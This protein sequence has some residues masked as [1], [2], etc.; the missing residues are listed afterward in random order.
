M[1]A[2]PL[3]TPVTKPEERSTEA[4]DGSLLVQTPLGMELVKVIALEAPI[5]T[6]LAPIIGVRVGGGSTVTLAVVVP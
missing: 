4:I 3:A 1:M 2:V 5:Q 6:S